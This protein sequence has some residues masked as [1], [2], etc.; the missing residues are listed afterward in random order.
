MSTKKVPK[1][2]LYAMRAIYRLTFLRLGYST[3]SGII[4]PSEVWGPYDGVT[5]SF[6]AAYATTQS[7]KWLLQCDGNP[8]RILIIGLK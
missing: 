1:F 3:W 2:Y 4:N 5:Y 8:N 6:W 7:L